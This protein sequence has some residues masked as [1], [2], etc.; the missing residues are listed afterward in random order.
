VAGGEAGGQLP[1]IRVPGRG[2]QSPATAV[3][4]SSEKIDV[5]AVGQRLEN[6][7]LAIRVDSRRLHGP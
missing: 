2:M 3:V 7:I 5:S 6:S 4:Q 1:G